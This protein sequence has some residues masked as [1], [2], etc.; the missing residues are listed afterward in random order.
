[1]TVSEVTKFDPSAFLANSRM[2]REL[3]SLKAKQTFFTQ[4]NQADCILYL[5]TGRAKPTVVSE[6]GKEA[7]I[8]LLGPGDFI[9]E[10]SIASVPGLRLATAAAITACTALRIGRDEMIRVIWRR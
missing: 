6:R 1:M 7:T 9:G 2:G 5:Q 8:T 3:V 4:G 10:E